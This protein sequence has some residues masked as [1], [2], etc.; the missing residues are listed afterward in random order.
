MLINNNSHGL[1]VDAGQA[2]EMLGVKRATLYAYVSRGK[3]RA[4]RAER[5]RT[6]LY[7]RDDV[8]RLRAAPGRRG[9]AGSYSRPLVETSLTIQ[10]SVGPH[11]R[12]RAAIELASDPAWRFEDTCELL[13]VGS[14]SDAGPSGTPWP[15][16]T[17]GRSILVPATGDALNT[18]IGTVLQGVADAR[19]HDLGVDA[20]LRKSRYLMRLALAGVN[21]AR[22]PAAAEWALAQPS[23][24]AG[25][26]AAYG[27]TALPQAQRAIDATLTLVTDEGLVESALATRAVIAAGGELYRAVASGLCGLTLGGLSPSLAVTPIAALLDETGAPEHAPA[28]IRDLI[29]RRAPVPGFSASSDPR[30]SALLAHAEALGGGKRALRVVRALVDAAALAGLPGP[31]LALGLLAV[32]EALG[33]G[34]EGAVAL[35]ALGRCGGL[36]AHALEQSAQGPV[37]LSQRYVGPPLRDPDGLP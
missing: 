37:P 3:V 15:K 36:I 34:S 22:D 21:L 9:V 5:G 27:E 35:L 17:D 18:I 4:Q 28:R 1:W 25:F 7:L 24:A 19:R 30:A 20:D 14:S 2:C 12:G 26:A 8:E 29:G 32:A 10:T 33:V 16:T 6:R 11:L 13:W 23:V 31:D